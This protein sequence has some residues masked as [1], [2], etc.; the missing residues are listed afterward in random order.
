MV[1]P[2]NAPADVAERSLQAQYPTVLVYCDKVSNL[3]TEK[4]RS[5][6]GKVHITVEVRQSQDRL[7][8]IDRNSQLYCDAVCQLLDSARGNWGHGAFY[9]GG[10][11]ASFGAVKQGGR[12]FIQSTKIGFEVQVSK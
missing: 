8:E 5:F 1:L 4:F 6:S 9:T 11:E 3:L 2:R 7:E 12:N 10:Y